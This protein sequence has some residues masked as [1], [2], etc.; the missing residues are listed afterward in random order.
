MNTER[1]ASLPTPTGLTMQAG[2]NTGIVRRRR[3]E[4]ADPG[5]P[6]ARLIALIILCIAFVVT[7]QL[8]QAS[9][10]PKPEAPSTKIEPPGGDPNVLAAK[11]MVKL[12]HST[13]FQQQGTGPSLLHEQMKPID[14]AAKT[15]VDR[16]RAALVA[17]EL[18]GAEE[19][20]TRIDDLAKAHGVDVLAG[21]GIDVDALDRAGEIASQSGG[22]AADA[23]T[24][25]G[26]ETQSQAGAT[27][28]PAF[29]PELGEDMRAARKIYSGQP[30][31]VSEQA[32]AA[33]VDRHG[34]YGKLAVT[35]DLPETDPARQQLV[36]GGDQL[37]AM[38]MVGVVLF[39]GVF[40]AGLGVAV[41][42]TVC[43]AMGKVRW[44]FQAPSP[45]GSVYLETV[46]VFVLGF[47]VFKLVLEGLRGLIPNPTDAQVAMLT[48]VQWLMVLPIF[49]PLL[50]GVKLR[51]MRASMGLTTGE[52]LFREIA[53][54]VLAYLAGIPVFLGVVF[55]TLLLVM[56]WEMIKRMMGWPPSPPPENPLVDL[57][58]G[59][60]T[61]T[62]IAFGIL[63][64]VWAPL[65]EESIFRG[66]LFRHARSR[67]NVV[68]AAIASAMVF[69]GMH[70][71]QGLLLLPVTSLGVVFALMR[72]WR[73]S[74]VA[75]MTAH[76][77]HNATVTMV[78][79]AVVK[80]LSD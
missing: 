15:P 40:L 35:R 39:I 17:G 75:P 63:A 55:L 74:L 46:A 73:G 44:R 57:F 56:I 71:Y 41:W 68:L 26:A 31:A 11:M 72:E 7:F 18:I 42:F 52:G 64:T 9:T 10:A 24:V 12:A 3:R 54:G 8:Q 4:E 27:P 50:R 13:M 43:V 29:P 59:G 77:L 48:S 37:V 20:V 45:G 67:V 16:F 19:T 80:M 6:R 34:W 36:G 78:M 79:V 25:P 76:F 22:D 2:E 58:G 66:C 28:E 5:S 33:L 21:Q 32:R 62:L 30:G 51:D 47:L 69:G 65:V 49:W 53:A 38:L 1:D 70:G 23:S 61:W 14:E 60:G